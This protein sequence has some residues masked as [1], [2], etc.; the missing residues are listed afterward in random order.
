M[1]WYI[2][3]CTC[4]YLNKYVLVHTSTYLY[5]LVCTST[6]KYVL[7]CTGMYLYILV[8]TAMY[9]Y[10]SLIFSWLATQP[11]QS[12]TSSASTRVQDFPWAVQTRQLLM[13]GVAATC[14]RST[15]G[16]G[17]LA[18]ESLSWVAGSDSGGD[19]H[20]EEKCERGPSQAFC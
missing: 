8:C 3:L 15:L 4:T 2:P 20:A 5:V 9:W 11:L 6:Y 18:V 1:Y 13:A 19:R 10:I 14:T 17:T 16:C 12:H 7:V